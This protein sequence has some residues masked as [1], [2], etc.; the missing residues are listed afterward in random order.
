MKYFIYPSP[1]FNT[2]LKNHPHEMTEVKFLKSI[3][4]KGELGIYRNALTL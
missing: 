3:T 2:Y 1:R 4:K